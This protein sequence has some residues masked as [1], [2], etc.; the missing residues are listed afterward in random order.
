MDILNYIDEMW[1]ILG[2]IALLV[3]LL[4][5]VF[6]GIRRKTVL[7]ATKSGLIVASAAAAF[8]LA[9]LFG[10]ML[11]KAVYE[12]AGEELIAQEFPEIAADASVA[13]LM[14]TLFGMACAA[15]MFLPCWLVIGLLML[16]PYFL[17]KRAY[18]R[19]NGKPREFIGSGVLGGF[20]GGITGLFVF[21]VAA[22]PFVGV[23]NTARL[24]LDTAKSDRFSE[25]EEVIERLDDTVL[26]RM[27]KSVGGKLVY[28][29]LTAGKVD[30]EWVVLDDE[31]TAI[32][33]LQIIADNMAAGDG[34]EATDP[35]LFG[36][37]ADAIEASPSGRIIAAVVLRNSAAEW[38][39]GNSYLG[40]KMSDLIGGNEDNLAVS[41]AAEALLD[42]FDTITKDN[43]VAVVR[44]TEDMLRAV[45]AMLDYFD[46]IGEGGQEAVAELE[47]ALANF[48]ETSLL[49]LRGGIRAAL[50][51][52]GDPNEAR[53]EACTDLLENVFL[54]LSQSVSEGADREQL[55][56][57][58]ELVKHIYEDE[59]TVKYLVTAMLDSA[60]VADATAELYCVDDTWA[61]DPF[62]L[63]DFVSPAEER[64]VR[65][66]LA[67]H[68]T[69]QNAWFIAGVMTMFGFN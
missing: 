36:G 27:V 58:S 7:Q 23:F 67:D 32:H 62:D 14:K 21:I 68:L 45:Q 6:F 33:D 46:R 54:R 55:R 28:S 69:P 1:L 65:E 38:R 35:A 34:D 47:N 5:G 51:Q 63:A 50:E 31:L 44:E 29:G 8:F 52:S 10:H 53:I 42:Q 16:V 13:A 9:W 59:L 66:M 64:E 3:A 18:C 43:V 60:I 2:C 17:I 11:G 20:L 39:E 24:V 56:A 37:Y 49:V 15:L 40:I 61:D 30:D 22:A 4:C 26:S 48:N 41:G 12:G 19:G 25:S 57:V